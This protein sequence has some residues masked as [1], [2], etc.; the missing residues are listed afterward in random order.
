[1]REIGKAALND[2]SF[3]CRFPL[4]GYLFVRCDQFFCLCSLHIGDPFAHAG[5]GYGQYGESYVRLS[6]TLPDASLVK[7]LSRLAEWKDTK[8]RFK[9]KIPSS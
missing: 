5:I 3:T 2:V 7:G 6:L 1:M 4:L 9:S 8:N